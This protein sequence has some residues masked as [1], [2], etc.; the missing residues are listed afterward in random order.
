MKVL[1]YLKAIM[2]PADDVRAPEI[3]L[4][5]GAALVVR[6]FLPG[7]LTTY[8]VDEPQQLRFLNERDLASEGTTVESLHDRAMRNLR[9]LAAT[10]LRVAA[11]GPIFP[12][13]IDGNFEA[14]A[15]LLDEL[16]DR[17]LAPHVAGE[18]VAAVPARDVLAVGS[19]AST[20]AVQELRGLIGRLWPTGDHLLSD[21]L[22]IRRS[23]SWQFHES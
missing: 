10:Q 11:H 18:I 2:P 15:L 21:K 17:G 8:V 1:P 23:G 3:Q 12:V 5:G 13:F 7:L 16:W 22:L 9:E 20:A 19:A 14:S 6:P 4:D